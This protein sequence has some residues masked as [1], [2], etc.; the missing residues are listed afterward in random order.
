MEYGKTGEKF[1]FGF[2]N[3]KTAGVGKISDSRKIS[4][5]LSGKTI[6]KKAVASG[7][8]AMAVTAVIAIKSRISGKKQEG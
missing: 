7:L 5:K 3:T 1:S 8:Q 4:G 2:G 6:A